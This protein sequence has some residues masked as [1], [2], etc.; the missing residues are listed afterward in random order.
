[1]TPL[2]TQAAPH[3]AEPEAD[4]PNRA[5]MNRPMLPAKVTNRN[6]GLTSQ[7]VP[8]ANGGPTGVLAGVAGLDPADLDLAGVALGDGVVRP[9]FALFVRFWATDE[10]DVSGPPCPTRTPSN[11]EGG[12]VDYSGPSGGRKH[13]VVQHDVVLLDR[14]PEAPA[15][16]MCSCGWT[17]SANSREEAEAMA[18]D[19]RL[20]QGVG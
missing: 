7:A 4:V 12:N 20:S 2:S 18:D 13:R 11:A 3:T 9:G 14:S 10:R 15:E 1:M 6:V 5:P 8:R 17:W 19:H 16:V